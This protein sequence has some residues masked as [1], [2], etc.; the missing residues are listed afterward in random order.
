[1]VPRLDDD[2]DRAGG[3]V[4]DTAVPSVED[5][6]AREAGEHHLIVNS[7]V[8]EPAELRID[9]RERVAVSGELNPIFWLP[10]DLDAKHDGG[11]RRRRA[12][13]QR[14]HALRPLAGG[15]LAQRDAPVCR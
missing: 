15:E 12:P 8:M 4:N 13:S 1:L 10:L 2:R 6:G 14:R 7:A 5:D 11:A 3:S 9:G